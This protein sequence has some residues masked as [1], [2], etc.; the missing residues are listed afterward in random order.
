VPDENCREV[1]KVEY[2]VADD[3]C[4]YEGAIG[5]VLQSAVHIVFHPGHEGH[6]K[7]DGNKETEDGFNDDEEDG[8][9]HLLLD[10]KP[11][12][13]GDQV[14]HTV[15]VSTGVDSQAGVQDDRGAGG[16]D[17]GGEEGEEEDMTG[18]EED[19]DPGGEDRDDMQ[20]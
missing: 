19:Q 10:P 15:P 5:F 20:Q 4:S 14:Y 2:S 3:N 1:R 9:D 13:H 6:E 7:Q 8:G 17:D 11:G 16:D 18:D 12:R